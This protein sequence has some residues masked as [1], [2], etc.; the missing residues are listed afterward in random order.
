MTRAAM[1]QSY[2][3]DK[4]RVAKRYG[5]LEG[6]RDLEMHK[7][8]SSDFY[9]YAHTTAHLPEEVFL[10]KQTSTENTSVPTVRGVLERRPKEN[11]MPSQ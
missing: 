6:Y 2:V 3:L 7:E 10:H 8:R 4:K 11:G 1:L 9:W 5:H